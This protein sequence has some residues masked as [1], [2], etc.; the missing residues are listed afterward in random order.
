[1]TFYTIY[2]IAAEN[3]VNLSKEGVVVDEEASE[4]SGTSASLLHGD[5]ITIEQL[6]YA[7][8]LPSGNDAAVSLAKWGGSLINSNPTHITHSSAFIH[9]MNKHAKLLGLKFTIFGNPHG[10]PNYRNISNPYDL[11]LLIAECLKINLFCKIVGTQL[12]KITIFN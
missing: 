11:S 3:C 8:M 1:M 6:L 12:Y 7:L 5:K 2:Q 9:R 4:M 10:L